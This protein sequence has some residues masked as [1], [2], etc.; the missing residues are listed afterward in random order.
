MEINDENT[1]IF[2]KKNILPKWRQFVAVPC[3][4][5]IEEKVPFLS[6]EH[7]ICSTFF[8]AKLSRHRSIQS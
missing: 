7:K 8:L 5:R 1:E 3:Y 4:E 2:K 6:Q